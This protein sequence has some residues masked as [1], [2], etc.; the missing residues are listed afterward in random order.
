MV[1]TYTRF[2]PF[3][4]FCFGLYGLVCAIDEVDVG[5]NN[6]NIKSIVVFM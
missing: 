1:G 5:G 2:S 6:G 3:M 4:C